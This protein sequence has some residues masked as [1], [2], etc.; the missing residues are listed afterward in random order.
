MKARTFLAFAA[1]GAAV[2]G[3]AF[4]SLG[5]MHTPAVRRLDRCSTPRDLRETHDVLGQLLA[6][7]LREELKNTPA[8]EMG[9]HNLALGM[10]LRNSWGLW[11]GS[12]L[13]DHL[14]SLGLRH[15]D[16]MSELVLVTFRSHRHDQ[17][18]RVEEEAARLRAADE[19]AEWRPDPQCHCVQIGRCMPTYVV[20]PR[21]GPDR[22]FAVS[23]CCC[24]RVPQIAEGKPVQ[25][26]DRYIVFPFEFISRDRVCGAT[27]NAG[28]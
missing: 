2:V 25:G 5:P 24:G 8:G 27:F 17:P 16:D 21:M 14:R 10:W 22:G 9:K 4:P 26:R 11:N 3:A 28:T 13:R 20:D 1:S 18:L 12:P 19:A 23:D 7:G 15:P 6:P